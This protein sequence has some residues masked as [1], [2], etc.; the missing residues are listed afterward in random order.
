VEAFPTPNVF[1]IVLEDLAEGGERLPHPLR[2][3][4]GGEFGR[5]L[6][7]SA[8]MHLS[9]ESVKPKVMIRLMLCAFQYRRV[10]PR[11]PKRRRTLKLYLV[12]SV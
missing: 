9:V 5:E 10:L 4:P 7:N 1:R 8:R 12:E 3:S 11:C 2:I 6:P